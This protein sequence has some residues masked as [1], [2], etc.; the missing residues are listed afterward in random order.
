[1]LRSLGLVLLVACGSAP[2]PTS[3]PPA[4]AAQRHE[5]TVGVATYGNPALFDP[6]IEARIADVLAR[7]SIPW[8]A[9]GSLGFTLHVP[10]SRAAEARSLLRADA[11]LAGKIRVVEEAAWRAAQT[12]A[13]P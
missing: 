5:P 8:T 4:A 9:G 6:A 7:A 1:M 13:T 12:P 10:A 11:Q 3:T 2:A